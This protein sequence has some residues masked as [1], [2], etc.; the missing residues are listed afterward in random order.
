MRSDRKVFRA[1]ITGLRALA[2][3]AVVLFHFKVPGFTGGFAGVDIFFV[4]SGFLMT[5]IIV[6][7]LERREFSIFLFYSSR[8]RRIIPALSVVCA[9]VLF[10]GWW[11]L[12]VNDYRDLGKYTFASIAFLSNFKYWKE[13]G[14]FSPN[15]HDNFLLHTWS[16]SVEWQFY[17]L[18]P[19][20]IMAIW[21]MKPQ[22]HFLGMV[23]IAIGTVSYL[24]CGLSTPTDSNA[25]FYLLPSRAWEMIIGGLVYLW[26]NL[27]VLNSRLKFLL[28]LIGFALA[29]CS[30]ALLD[31]D[32]VWPGWIAI[33]PVTSAAL[34]LLANRNPS[35]LTHN[36]IAQWIGLRSYSIYLWH[37]P[38]VV[39]LNYAGQ[40]GQVPAMLCGLL[41]TLALGHFS[42]IWI[43]LS[44]TRHLFSRIKLPA[45]WIMV[46][47]LFVASIGLGI[48]W[49]NGVF[50]RVSKEADAISA[51]AFDKNP[52]NME[53]VAKAGS[54]PIKCIYGETSPPSAIILGDSHAG[55]L[56]SGLAKVTLALPGPNK[57]LEQLTFSACPTAEGVKMRFDKAN[58]CGKFV[59]WALRE[60]EDIPKDTPVVI[61]NRHAFH[62]RGGNEDH[63]NAPQPQVF[64]SQEYKNVDD[65]L[66]AEYSGH[67]VNTACK[68]AK[69][70]PVY[71]V[72]PIP[73]MGFNIPNTARSIL[74]GRNKE[75]TLSLTD[76]HAR[77][78][79]AWSAQDEAK[80]QCGIKILDPLPYLCWDG[81]CHSLANG[82]P[83]YTDDNHLTQFGSD[84]L[85]PMF[86]SIFQ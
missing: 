74:F 73:E 18:L 37:W 6:N 84:L 67:I 24:Y 19:I 63:I 4:I 44:A 43:E 16:L 55:S 51:G 60:L 59:D 1:D 58:S 79:F 8:I 20:F 80:R 85:Q 36:A 76:Y 27:F 13:S 33:L 65:R 42:Y 10:I 53:C 40:L 3:I 12:P 23:L 57:S 32:I 35:P 83:I 2:V 29:F 46:S 69:K 38:I 31:N 71:M 72:R 48:F 78:H 22:R 17:I 26:G 66:I 86:Q 49:N 41:A 21:R 30:L 81:V 39:T 54:K 56:V 82:K 5:G 14:Y 28:E 34:I 7:G 45:M 75:T 70:H 64:F 25:A 9:T 11:T 68:I 47:G 62:I 52:R 50:G 77:N 15:A 61:A